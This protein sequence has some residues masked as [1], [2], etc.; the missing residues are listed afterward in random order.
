[1][2]HIASLQILSLKIC[3]NI[4]TK[5]LHKSQRKSIDVIVRIVPPERATDHTEESHHP[6]PDAL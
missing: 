3:N 2:K 5:L 6:T 1:M 4:K